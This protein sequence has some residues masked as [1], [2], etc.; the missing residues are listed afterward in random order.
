MTLKLESDLDIP[1]MYLHI[2]NEV[3]RVR[4]SKLL[5]KNT[6]IYLKVKEQ[7]QMSPMSNNFQ[8]SS[9]GIF[10]PSYINF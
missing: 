3:A 7:G 1:K 9:W 6:K 4:H 5:M 2:K 8:H 10:L